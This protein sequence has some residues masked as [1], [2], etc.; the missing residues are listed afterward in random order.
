M[1]ES[2][3]QKLKGRPIKKSEE[4]LRRIKNS[5][6]LITIN[7]NKPMALTADIINEPLFADLQV[8]LS[9]LFDDRNI[10]NYILILS[11]GDK[12]DLN[13]FVS[14]NI[15]RVIEY[16]H[17]NHNIHSH[18]LVNIR[19]RT[20]VLIDIGKMRIKIGNALGLDHFYFNC[21][22]VIPGMQNAKD[23]IYKDVDVVD[24]ADII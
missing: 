17:D 8:L 20:K 19:H 3:S 24:A 13:N 21:K 6:F 10:V 14:I 11:E 12:F 16:G 7:P 2:L 1:S 4:K 22:V 15:D 23:Y 9:D 18:T 5:S